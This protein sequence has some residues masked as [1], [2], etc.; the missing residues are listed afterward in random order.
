MQQNA[1]CHS[2]Q[3]SICTKP[4]GGIIQDRLGVATVPL[5]LLLAFLPLITGFLSLE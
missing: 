1:K 3:R 5:S 4:V 2:L